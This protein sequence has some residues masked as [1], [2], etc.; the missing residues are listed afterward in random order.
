M[1]VQLIEKAYERR[2]SDIGRRLVL[3][4]QNPI[5]RSFSAIGILKVEPDLSFSFQDFDPLVPGRRKPAGL[6]TV[7]KRA[8]GVVQ[9]LPAFFRA[10]LMDE[11]REDFQSY[12]QAFELNAPASPIELLSRSAGSRV[13]D[14][15]Q[16]IE[17]ME[18]DLNGACHQYLFVSGVRHVASEELIATLNPGK[19][20][21]RPDP[22]NEFN[23]KALFLVSSDQNI[24]FVPDWMLM[25]LDRIESVGGSYEFFL[26]KIN[27]P[28]AGSHMRLLATLDIKVPPGTN[29]YPEWLPTE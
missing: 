20:E 3:V 16:V 13:T 28:E 11:K 10:R 26:K 7:H 6:D 19:L 21:V 4:W 8:A 17:I 25:V 15:F 9:S 24:G 14:T 27:G 2:A 18:P 23:S 29:L 5:T 22:F 1:S 12:V